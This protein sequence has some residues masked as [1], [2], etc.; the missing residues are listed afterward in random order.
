MNDK[1][2]LKEAIEAL[3][4][5]E[6]FWNTTPPGQLGKIVCDIGLLNDAFLKTSKVL[7]FIK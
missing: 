2:L 3:K 7:R 4:A 1:E 6:L 5:W